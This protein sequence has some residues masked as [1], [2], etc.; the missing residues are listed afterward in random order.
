MDSLANH[1][2]L[3]S[4]CPSL[5]AIMGSV[6]M[7]SPC[8]LLVSEGVKRSEAPNQIYR[9]AGIDQDADDLAINPG[10]GREFARPVGPVGGPA[11]PSCLVRFPFGRMTETVRRAAARRN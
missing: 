1:A 7:I 3:Y 8:R 10:N 9:L 5:P 6:S 11:N 2:G 4:H